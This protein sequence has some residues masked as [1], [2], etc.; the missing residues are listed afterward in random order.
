MK[1]NLLS[2]A[3]ISVLAIA[4]VGCKD[5]LVKDDIDAK[6]NRDATISAPVVTNVTDAS[7]TVTYTAEFDTTNLVGVYCGVVLSTTEDFS[8]DKIEVVLAP[9]AQKSVEVKADT[10]Y[11]A[12]SY[13]VTGTGV[14][15]SEVKTF[16]TEKAK[17]FEDKYLWGTYTAYDDGVDTVTY[18]MQISWV[19][20]T[21]N[22]IN[23]INWWDGGETVT[24]SVD[25]EKKQIVVE[26]EPKIFDYSVLEPSVGWVIFYAV[27]EEGNFLDDVNVIG[28]YDDKGN[29]SFPEY[30][31]FIEEV[32]PYAYGSTDMVKQ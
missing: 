4:F 6:Y 5:D 32:G 16:Q 1:R 12:K 18:E 8:G 27:D 19:E 26:L 23:I 22:K 29:I 17:E 15:Y 21:S 2:I 13:I 24:A 3:L 7:A 25:F 20:G 9:G 31:I 28:T 30:G 10:R 11:Y 14:E